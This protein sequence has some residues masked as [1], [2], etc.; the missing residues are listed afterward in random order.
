MK[1]KYSSSNNNKNPYMI[2]IWELFQELNVPLNL[3][4]LPIPV[5]TQD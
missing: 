1:A 2:M 5:K 3:S 4:M